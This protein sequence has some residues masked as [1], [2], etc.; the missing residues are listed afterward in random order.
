M[1]TCALM[2]YAAVTLALIAGGGGCFENKHP[3]GS[4]QPGKVDLKYIGDWTLRGDDKTVHILIRNLHNDEY[5]V[6]WAAEGEKPSRATGYLTDIKGVSFANILPITDDDTLADRYL[7]LRVDL[8][9]GDTLK[10]RNLK[11]DFFSDAQREK[12]DELRKIV[13]DNLDNHAMYQG[14]PLVAN[15]APAAQPK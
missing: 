12:P 3:L 4:M 2:A 6:E 15:R 11:Q 8:Q 13:A 10:L 14:D 5:Y 1:K 9:G 7:I